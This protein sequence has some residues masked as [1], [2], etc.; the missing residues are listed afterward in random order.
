M[1]SEMKICAA[2]TEEEIQS[3]FPVVKQLRPHLSEKEFVSQVRRQMENHGYRLI[4]VQGNGA[5]K[6]VGG[7]RVA[8][9]LA[10][11]KTLYVDDLITNEA[12]RK[13]GFG[14]M[15]L[16]WLMQEAKN[17]GCVEFHLDSG[18]HRFDAHRLYLIKRMIISSHHF[19]KKVE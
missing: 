2:Q 11:G 7:F 1:K 15:V 13:S 18:V 9:F 10:W 6:A 16:D 8:E 4:F 19:S 3:C 12:D 5:A 14:G 17:L